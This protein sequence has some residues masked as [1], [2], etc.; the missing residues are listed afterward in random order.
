MKFEASDL[1]RGLSSGMS[2]VK[3]YFETELSDKDLFELNTKLG[4]V[5]SAYP[6]EL[7]QRFVYLFAQMAAIA[8]TSRLNY[9]EPFLK[10]EEL[11]SFLSHS[12]T[13]FNS[14]THG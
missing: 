2:W 14:F 7:N 8:E 6:S 13:F 9:K 1:Q 12:S 3:P 11:A 10:E 5:L 4:K